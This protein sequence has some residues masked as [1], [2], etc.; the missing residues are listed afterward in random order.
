MQL[1][2]AITPIGM[3]ESTVSRSNFKYMYWNM[4]QQLAHHTSN[5]CNVRIGDLMAS[6]T[7]SGPTHE[8]MGSMLELSWGGK[9]PVTLSNGQTR[10]FIE[11]GDRVTL[12]GW[13]EKDGVRVG[14]GDVYNRIVNESWPGT[15]RS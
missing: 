11:D 8:S 9:T 13:A 7:I 12:R 3:E 4:C 15:V 5:G 1:E 10:S 2:V 6:G 14:F